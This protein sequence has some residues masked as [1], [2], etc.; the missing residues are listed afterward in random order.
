MLLVFVYSVVA[1]HCDGLCVGLIACA[2]YFSERGNTSSKLM[3][4]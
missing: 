1:C 3:C 4:K 2:I